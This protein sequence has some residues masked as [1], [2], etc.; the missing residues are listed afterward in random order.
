MLREMKF[1]VVF[2]SEPFWGSVLE[3]DTTE[4]S[5]LREEAS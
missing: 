5:N 4:K 3:P 2:T 1:K